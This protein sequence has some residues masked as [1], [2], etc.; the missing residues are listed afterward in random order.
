MSEKCLRTIE[1]Y[2]PRL[3]NDPDMVDIADI[4]DTIEVGLSDVRAARDIRIQYDFDRDGYVITAQ[5]WDSDFASPWIEVGF[6]PG[7]D[8]KES[9]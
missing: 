6:V 1:L 8:E 3:A 2:Y 4:V 5:K 9:L 7:S